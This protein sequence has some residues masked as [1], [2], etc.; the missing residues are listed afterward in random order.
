M[1]L[2]LETSLSITLQNLC[3]EYPNQTRADHKQ[4][5]AEVM[6]MYAD[7]YHA[8]TG[9]RWMDSQGRGIVDYMVQPMRRSKD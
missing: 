1:T 8:C 7:K 9:R 4:A 3:N 2:K 6:I 5:L